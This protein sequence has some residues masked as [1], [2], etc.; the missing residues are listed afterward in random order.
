M[1]VFKTDYHFYTSCPLQRTSIQYLE[2]YFQTFPP[3]KKYLSKE[4]LIFSPK[5]KL[6]GFC[7]DS[8]TD[9]LVDPPAHP[10][11]PGENSPSSQIDI[12]CENLRQKLADFQ[13]GKESGE[14]GKE[15]ESRQRNVKPAEKRKIGKEM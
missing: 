12:I 13:L 5:S 4:F 9:R 3:Q 1:A 6:T 11:E 8:L 15:M 2:V 10:H 7:A 14:I